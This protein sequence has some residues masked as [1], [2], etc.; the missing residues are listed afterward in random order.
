MKNIRKMQ[1]RRCRKEED[2]ENKKDV[3]NGK[4]TKNSED[5]KKKLYK[6]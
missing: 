3:G 2:I 1:K 5:V 6:I 4:N